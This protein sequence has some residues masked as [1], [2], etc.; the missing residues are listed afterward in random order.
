MFFKKYTIF[1][2]TTIYYL[3]TP[4]FLNTHIIADDISDKKTIQNIIDRSEYQDFLK[5][6]ESLISKQRESVFD[7]I[8]KYLYQLLQNIFTQN[9][10]P[11]VNIINPFLN[12]FSNPYIFICI[13]IIILA[14]LTY[15]M[16]KNYIHKLKI[17]NTQ[18]NTYPNY[19]FDQ[20]PDDWKE[21]IN[22]ILKYY[23]TPIQL[24]L[25]PSMTLRQVLQTLKDYKKDDTFINEFVEF[26]ERWHFSNWHPSKDIIDKWYQ[27]I[28]AKQN[29]LYQALE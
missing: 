13:I 17:K 24:S 28:L 16:Y 25:T 14:I 12:L 1:F 20:V 2:I 3:I 9:T 29:E 6:Y 4:F 19:D 21:L 18:L 7:S 11:N 23:L 15:K 26:L 22:N 5:E 10:V 8:K 27:I